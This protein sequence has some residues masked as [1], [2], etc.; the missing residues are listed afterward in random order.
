M[1][2]SLKFTMNMIIRKNNDRANCRPR[3]LI[4]TVSETFAAGTSTF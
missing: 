1:E 3:L 4:G 2:D